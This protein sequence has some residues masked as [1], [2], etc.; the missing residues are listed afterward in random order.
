MKKLIATVL[1]LTMLATVLLCAPV[2]AADPGTVGGVP[3]GNAGEGIIKEVYIDHNF[4]DAVIDWTPYLT[5]PTADPETGAISMMTL[6]W[7]DINLTNNGS[8]GNIPWTTRNSSSNKGQPKS[9]TNRG[10]L[11]RP[12]SI[13]TYEDGTTNKAIMPSGTK[14]QA[15]ADFKVNSYT[16]E[17]NEETEEYDTVITPNPIVPEQDDKLYMD[18]RVRRLGLTEDPVTIYIKDLAGKDI[19]DIVYNGSKYPQLQASMNYGA[20]AGTSTSVTNYPYSTDWVYIRAIIR[21]DNKTFQLYVGDSLDNLVP[22]IDDVETYTFKSTAAANFYNV[23]ISTKGSLGIDDFKVYSVEPPVVPVA[24]DVAMTGKPNLD[25][26][27]TGTYATYEGK[28][29]DEGASYC[30]W[31]AS[32]VNTFV[33]ATKITEDMPITAGGINEYTLTA[34]ETGKYVRFCVVPVN[35]LGTPGD[36]V[37]SNATPV[38]VNDIEATLGISGNIKNNTVWD[39]KWSTNNYSGTVSITSS[40][41]T[42]ETFKL[43]AAWY[44]TDPDTNAHTLVS[45]KSVDVTVDEASATELGYLT[46]SEATEIVQSVPSGTNGTYLTMKVMLFDKMGN[47]KPLKAYK[48][49]GRNF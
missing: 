30:Y 33:G 17:Y 25:S 19:F 36:K 29:H 8:L 5:D 41:Q 20:E 16:Q 49:A 39:F 32:D 15:N 37:Y 38:K 14:K 12:V 31:E 13:G 47:V 1:S 27:L 10:D 11:Y 40:L 26:T 21:F 4:D 18:I 22:Y 48:Y 2:F 35:S 43:V 45:V 28:G 44:E 23:N 7:I 3:A 6:Q 42:A 9:M 24:S 34:N 46:T